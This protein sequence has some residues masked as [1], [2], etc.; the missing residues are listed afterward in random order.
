MRRPRKLKLLKQLHNKKAARSFFKEGAAFLFFRSLCPLHSRLCLFEEAAKSIERQGY[1]MNDIDKM[2]VKQFLL[3]VRQEGFGI[4]ENFPYSVASELNIDIYRGKTKICTFDD[5]Q[6]G[7]RWRLR[8]HTDD[9]TREEIKQDYHKLFY[10]LFTCVTY[11]RY[12][13]PLFLYR[14]TTS[15]WGIEPSCS[16]RLVSSR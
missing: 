3:R 14:A 15:H 1:L 16:I 8:V 9:S 4:V 5:R 10:N 12:T 13:K 6:L 11:M 7:E 2:L